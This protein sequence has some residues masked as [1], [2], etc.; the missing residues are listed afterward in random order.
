MVSAVCALVPRRLQ[1]VAPGQ[2]AAGNP[3]P[4]GWLTFCLAD[5]FPPRRVQERLRPQ[6]RFLPHLQSSDG[7]E[8]LLRA[9]SAKAVRT[10]R[11][12]CQQLPEG[13][14]DEMDMLTLHF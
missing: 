7:V 2:G 4:T 9:A 13:A 3:F 8:P 6:V 11:Q 1:F 5:S 10:Q 14:C 12:F